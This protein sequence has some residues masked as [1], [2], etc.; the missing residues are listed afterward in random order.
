M[1]PS[2]KEFFT[3]FRTQ[4]VKEEAVSQEIAYTLFCP[5]IQTETRPQKSSK[6]LRVL[7]FS[8]RHFSCSIQTS[9]M[10]LTESLKSPWNVKFDILILLQI[11]KL[12]SRAKMES[13]PL[14]SFFNFQ[15][16]LCTHKGGGSEAPMAIKQGVKVGEQRPLATIHHKLQPLSSEVKRPKMI[17]T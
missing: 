5:Q 16:I 3:G 2:S 6:L 4:I 7:P 13:W 9:K 14:C 10:I 17:L 15:L 8:G 1:E 11:P 12:Q